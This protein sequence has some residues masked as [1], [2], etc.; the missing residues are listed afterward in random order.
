MIEVQFNRL[1]EYL[2]TPPPPV[3]TVYYKRFLYMLDF[4]LRRAGGGKVGHYREEK[5]KRCRGRTRLLG[6]SARCGECVLKILRL[7]E[8][9][10]TDT[11]LNKKRGEQAQK[12]NIAQCQYIS[13]PSSSSPVLI[14][15]TFFLYP[16]YWREKPTPPLWHGSSPSGP[17]MIDSADLSHSRASDTEVWYAMNN[18]QI[19]RTCM[20]IK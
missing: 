9:R 20:L 1:S 7:L 18:F 6:A 2:F 19:K 3:L 11:R 15:K 16:Q 17:P 5:I 14:H 13:F 8:C 4:K 10:G 12:S